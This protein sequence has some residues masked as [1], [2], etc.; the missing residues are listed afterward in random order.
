M[1]VWKPKV[2]R[3]PEALPDSEWF[4]ELQR[5]PAFACLNVKR[6]AEKCKL[7]CTTNRAFFS[8]RRFVN[9]LM[10]T[11]KNMTLS[12][13]GSQI[14]YAAG[15]QPNGGGGAQE[16]SGWREWISINRP[17]STYAY[18]QEKESVA[19]GELDKSI[20]DFIRKEMGI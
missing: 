8:R 10:H 19:W 15:Q 20:Q 7:W 3:K 9:W 14:H 16:P 5:S 18:G 17:D 13:S 11:E 12:N 1:P 6:E 2:K 4:I